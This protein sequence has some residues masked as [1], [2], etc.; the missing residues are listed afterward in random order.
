MQRARGEQPRRVGVRLVV[1]PALAAMLA[2]L[3]CT[4]E[5]PAAPSE[6]GGSAA[7]KTW[8]T[9]CGACHLP[10]PPQVLPARSWRKVMADLTNHFGEDASL[11]K[12]KTEEITQLLVYNAA[13]TPR[14]VHAFLR[15]L[16]PSEAP[17]R[18]TDTPEWRHIHDWLLGPGVGSGPGIRTAANCA[19]CHHGLGE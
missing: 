11:S 5:L 15:G 12:A 8:R 1:L 19:R 7:V 16:G 9:E 14:G 17:I 13:D 4:P 10:Y 6:S 3:A 2:M 18:V